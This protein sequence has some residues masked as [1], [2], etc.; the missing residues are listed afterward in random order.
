M[1][2]VTTRAGDLS[3][4]ESGAGD[5]LVLLHATLHDHH[6]FDPIVPQLA[7][8]HRVIALDWP[9]HGDSPPISGGSAV[10][11]PLLADLLEDVIDSLGLDR[12]GLIGNSVG[13]FA[14]ARFAATHPERVESLILV[15]SGGF[16]KMNVA[17]R[18][19]CAAMGTPPI[20]RAVMPLF[21]RSYMKSQSANDR[22]VADRVLARARTSE[23][24]STAAALWKSFSDPRHDL[25]AVAG[26]ITAP[27]LIVWGEKDTAI[28]LRDGKRAAELI[29]SSR[30]ETV[31]AGHLAFSSRPEEFLALVE[32]FLVA[33]GD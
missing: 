17:S 16:T 21:I 28:P 32:P 20:N 15:N 7:E 27:T 12:V 4:E 1:P 22:L 33:S 13:G 10:G 11:A 19:F 9:G 3:Y 8:T 26:Q 18:S 14:A 30:L 31:S 23:G 2:L 6:D 25:T 29:P 5:P 24:S